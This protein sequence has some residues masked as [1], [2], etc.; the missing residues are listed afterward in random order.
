MNEACFN[1]RTRKLTSS[2]DPFAAISEKRSSHVDGVLLNLRK[3]SLK[4]SI[5]LTILRAY[6]LKFLNISYSDKF[7]YVIYF[8][9]AFD[10]FKM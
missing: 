6:L 1:F 5:A 9:L 4:D 7:K 2:N 10:N 3:S 8:F